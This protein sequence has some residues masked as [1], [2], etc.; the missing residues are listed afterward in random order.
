MVMS[1]MSVVSLLGR[2]RTRFLFR[3]P[4][5]LIFDRYRASF[6]FIVVRRD[7]CTALFLSFGVRRRKPAF[8]VNIYWCLF[9]SR[10]KEGFIGIET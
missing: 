10:Q 3:S 4:G 9:E 7:S 5:S 8:V 2:N 1:K 6:R